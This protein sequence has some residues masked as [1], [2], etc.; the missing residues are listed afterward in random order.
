V[1][2]GSS[3]IQP[4]FGALSDRLSLAWLMPVG[5]PGQAGQRRV[6]ARPADPG[7]R[8]FRVRA[9]QRLAAG[10][11]Q[12]Q[13][14]GVQGPGHDPLRQHVAANEALRTGNYAKSLTL[15][16]STTAP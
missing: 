15:T 1:T 7:G 12:L 6:R 9:G 11:A 14:P 2:V 5:D 13:R 4:A 16:L 8:E 3:V 10:A